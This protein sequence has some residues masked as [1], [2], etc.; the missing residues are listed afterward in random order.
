[1]REAYSGGFK[2]IMSTT[3]KSMII[4]YLVHFYLQ[5]YKLRIRKLIHPTTSRTL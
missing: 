3:L 5:L 2:N 4:L 1:M